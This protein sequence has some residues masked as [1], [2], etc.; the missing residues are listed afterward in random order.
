MWEQESTRGKKNPISMLD[1]FEER[2]NNSWSYYADLT[3]R[4]EGLNEKIFH[5]RENLAIIRGGEKHYGRGFF[6]NTQKR[7]DELGQVYMKDVSHVNFK[8]GVISAVDEIRFK[9]TVFRIT[10]G[11][12]IINCI[13]FDD[14]FESL[15]DK[16]KEDNKMVFFVLF[17]AHQESY[18]DKKITRLVTTYCDKQYELPSK[19]EDF[20]PL[21]RSLQ[22]SYIET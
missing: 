18:L 14:I 17:P 3:A 20:D 12:C 21:I 22:E 9:R 4:M 16:E 2:V 5:Y 11:N 6:T 19:N 1:D 15:H 7:V 10:K 8:T 13:H